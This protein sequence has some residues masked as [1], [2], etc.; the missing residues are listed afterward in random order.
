M[1]SPEVLN[2]IV[3]RY[4]ERPNELLNECSAFLKEICAN[5]M[6]E[7]Q[8]KNSALSKKMQITLHQYCA[9]AYYFLDMHDRA[10]AALETALSLRDVE[11][12][13]FQVCC[14]SLLSAKVAL[15]QNKFLA[16]IFSLESA[17]QCDC[18]LPISV[19]YVCH[20]YLGYLYINIGLFRLS[21]GHFYCIRN[22]NRE[23]NDCF[24]V[25]SILSEAEN[26]QEFK[27]LVEAIC[28]SQED[29][30]LIIVQ[31]LIL[32]FILRRI[33]VRYR[34]SVVKHPKELISFLDS[35]AR[36]I[37]NEIL[38]AF[39]GGACQD[40]DK[41]EDI[42]RFTQDMEIFRLPLYFLTDCVSS[43][44]SSVIMEFFH[45][46]IDE[47]MD[48]N[49]CMEKICD[50]VNPESSYGFHEHGP[51]DITQYLSG[52]SIAKLDF[53]GFPKLLSDPCSIHMELYDSLPH[54][55]LLTRTEWSFLSLCIETGINKW[56][57]LYNSAVHGMS[58]RTMRQ[59]V[60]NHVNIIFIFESSKGCRLGAYVSGKAK[61]SAT[62]H[63]GSH[64]SFVFTNSPAALRKTYHTFEVY[65]PT[66][67]NKYFALLTQTYLSFGGGDACALR[68]DENFLE[69]YSQ[70]C[71][72]FG[73][74]RLLD[75]DYEELLS[76]ECWSVW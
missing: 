71:S 22:Q 7:K 10:H 49:K 18:E 37:G 2:H 31:K 5:D 66:E 42:I 68:I 8:V 29:T 17:L 4:T 70:P 19:S 54:K 16:A 27:G 14:S 61:S 15:K 35:E 64:T 46:K 1:D 33:S 13:G 43:F 38:H 28:S 30:N 59:M 20:F 24:T 23:A 47:H 73:S 21:V 44:R 60:H 34:K 45:L 72:T 50:I 57:L 11:S 25:F 65:R 48:F 26:V 63:F 41:T 53:E 62:V 69:V 3:F 39:T 40:I 32:Y 6:I 67:A 36:C 58:F 75:A 9:E 12:N 52:S 76:V 56:K 74:P 51:S 55:T